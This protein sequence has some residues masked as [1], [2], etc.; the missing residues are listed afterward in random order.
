MKKFL[1]LLPVCIALMV[2]M[3]VYADTIGIQIDG[4]TV[5]FSDAMPYIENGRTF[6]PVRAV[7]DAMGASVEWIESKKAVVFTKNVASTVYDGKTYTNA[8]MVSELKIGS[9]DIRMKLMQNGN[10]I[11]NIK[12]SMDTKAV[13]KNGRTYIPARFIGYALGYEVEW[14]DHSVH[15]SDIEKQTTDFEIDP[16]VKFPNK[17]RP[18]VAPSYA[19]IIKEEP[20]VYSY[21]NGYGNVK[22]INGDDGSLEFSNYDVYGNPVYRYVGN[23]IRYKGIPYNYIFDSEEFD[24]DLDKPAETLENF[25]KVFDEKCRENSLGEYYIDLD[26]YSLELSYNT[27]ENVACIRYYG[28]HRNNISW[29]I[30]NC[31]PR[32]DMSMYYY[33]AGDGVYLSGT[34]RTND[35]LQIGADKNTL[36][37]LHTFLGD[38]GERIWQMMSDYFTNSGL[39]SLPEKVYIDEFNWNKPPIDEKVPSM[40]GLQLISI[41]EENYNYFLTVYDPN[42]NKNVTIQYGAI[43]ANEAFPGYSVSW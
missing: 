5:D 36:L 42:T 13:I 23:F 16:N 14:K 38:T 24:I 39:Q 29:S 10:E 40:Y 2:A 3:T 43:A 8:Q 9:F 6:V 18:E 11:F 33:N 15:Y 25:K 19:Y 35:I 41:E 27:F 22:V 17:Y 28:D 20:I 4:Q 7:A 32:I 26:L 1:T 30:S 12:R 31:H 37:L 21:Y 34:K